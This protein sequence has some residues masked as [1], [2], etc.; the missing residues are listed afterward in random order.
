[1]KWITFRYGLLSRNTS[2]RWAFGWQK[3]VIFSLATS[4]LRRKNHFCPP[5]P[6][7]N[8]VVPRQNGPK[9]SILA[10]FCYIMITA[11]FW[12]KTHPFQTKQT[13]Y[14][15]DLDTILTIH[16]YNTG[17]KFLNQDFF[18]SYLPRRLFSYVRILC[19]LAILS[20]YK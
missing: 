14:F 4:W 16:T 13:R 9:R 11:C 17:Q 12:E 20:Q 3:W 8:S 6:H 1:M 10:C 15:P 19:C 2:F 18:R 5:Q 7:M